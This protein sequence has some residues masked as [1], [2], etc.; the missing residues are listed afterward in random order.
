VRTRHSIGPPWPRVLA[1]LA[2]A[3]CAAGCATPRPAPAPAAAAPPPGRVALPPEPAAALAAGPLTIQQL[4]ARALANNDTLAALRAAVRVAAERQ[5]A[6]RDLADPELRLNYGEGSVDNTRRRYEQ[7]AAGRATG[8][9]SGLITDED[10]A[11]E[12]G[13][14][15]FPPNPWVLPAQVSEAQAGLNAAQAALAQAEWAL[16]IEIRRLA[17]EILYLQKDLGVLSGLVVQSQ[18]ILDAVKQRADAGDAA[19]SDLLTASRRHLQALAQ[20]DRVRRRESARRRALAAL[21]DLPAEGLA[22]DPADAVLVVS[23]VT[24]LAAAELETRAL[25]H[26]ADLAML[27]WQSAAAQALYR[28]ARAQGWPWFKM[29]EASYAAARE[30]SR[31]LET[32]RRFGGADGGDSLTDTR[33]DDRSEGDEWQIGTAINIPLFSWTQRA[34]DLR[35]AEAELAR[36]REAEALKKLRRQ[37]RDALDDLKGVARQWAAYREETEPLLRA[38]QDAVAGVNPETDLT[39]EELAGLRTQILE[40][41][42]GRLEAA[43]EYTL[44]VINFEE[45]LGARISRSGAGR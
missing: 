3:A 15:F 9:Q 22:L 19:L 45:A 26:R 40:A 10:R 6:V 5:R 33:F 8:Q 21:A 30:N 28:Q 7:D 20:R 42:R 12:A 25:Q 31:G 35:A 13:L 11:Y 16:A 39:A 17:A 29:V 37:L 44:A 1:A 24:R 18:Q 32:A 36:I 14:R 38:M 34:D 43:Y 27:Y 23:N 41:Q 4:M 2:A